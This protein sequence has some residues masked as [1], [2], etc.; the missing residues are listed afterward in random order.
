MRLSMNSAT[1]SRHPSL[2]LLQS[3][4]A[5]GSGAL[6]NPAFPRRIPSSRS[7]LLETMRS[8]SLASSQLLHPSASPVRPVVQKHTPA[9]LEATSASRAL[10]PGA[11]RA[12]T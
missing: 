1:D 11:F 4:A 9:H 3:L 12:R 2:E 5:A 8:G 7:S 6:E 10:G